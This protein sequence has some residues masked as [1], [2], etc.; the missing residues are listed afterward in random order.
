[1]PNMLTEAI[2]CGVGTQGHGR[3]SVTRLGVRS[4]LLPDD[5]REPVMPD[6]LTL[7]TLS[8]VRSRGIVIPGQTMRGFR[9]R[10]SLLPTEKWGEPYYFSFGNKV[11][12]LFLVGGNH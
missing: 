4:S 5:E 12:A 7:A 11:G 2:L 10:S 6:M 3:H 1:M 9:V 8:V